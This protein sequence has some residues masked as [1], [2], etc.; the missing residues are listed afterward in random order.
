MLLIPYGSFKNVLVFKKLIKTFEDGWKCMFQL[1][2][3]KYN[4]LPGKAKS[5]LEFFSGR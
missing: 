1:F 3:G 5:E 2:D 4:F